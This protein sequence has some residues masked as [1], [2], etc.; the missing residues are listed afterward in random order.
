VSVSVVEATR[1]EELTTAASNLGGKVAQVN[2]QRIHGQT[3]HAEPKMRIT[4]AVVV[5]ATA[6]VAAAC[7]PFSACAAGS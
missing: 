7:S 4:V 1:P 2:S 6:L 3:N 5:C